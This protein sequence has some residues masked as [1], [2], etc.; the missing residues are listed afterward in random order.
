VHEGIL[1]PSFYAIQCLPLHARKLPWWLLL[2]EFEGSRGEDSLKRI[3]I[4]LL[5]RDKLTINQ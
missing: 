5:E 2:F 4:K 1:A 3:I